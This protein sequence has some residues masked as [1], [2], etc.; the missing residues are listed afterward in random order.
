MVSG[1]LVGGKVHTSL[2]GSDSQNKIEILLEFLLTKVQFRSPK[3]T[4]NTYKSD[5]LSTGPIGQSH[6]VTATLRPK[7]LFTEASSEDMSW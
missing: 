7:S 5:P 2:V 6:S 3:I 4:R 1:R